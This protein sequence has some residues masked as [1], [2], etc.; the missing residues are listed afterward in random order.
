[1]MEA[2]EAAWGVSTDGKVEDWITCGLPFCCSFAGRYGT[3]RTTANT[4]RNGFIFPVR[5]V[6]AACRGDAIA[7]VMFD[8]SD[9]PIDLIKSTNKT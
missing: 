9:D 1:M 4:S 7:L 3:V 6:L 5:A 8:E 2:Y